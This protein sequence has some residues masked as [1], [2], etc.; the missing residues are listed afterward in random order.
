MLRELLILARAEVRALLRM[1]YT[2][3]VIGLAWGMMLM[4]LSLSGHR[5]DSGSAGGEWTPWM[6]WVNPFDLSLPAN[7]LVW[8]AISGLGV[9]GGAVRIAAM[10]RDGRWH[11]LSGL[12]TGTTRT[13]LGIALGR[14]IVLALALAV[15][16]VPVGLSCCATPIGEPLWRTLTMLGVAWLV[17]AHFLTGT[18]ALACWLPRAWMAGAGATV[19]T[20]GWAVIST[21]YP[22]TVWPEI[23]RLFAGVGTTASP[24]WLLRSTSVGV[25][26]V[27]LVVVE[28]LTLALHIVLARVGFSVTRFMPRE[29]KS[30]WQFDRRNALIRGSIAIAGLAG[31]SLAAM[32]WPTDI[33]LTRARMTEPGAPLLQ[34]VNERDVA[35]ELRIPLDRGDSAIW[36]AYA[37]RLQ[38][39]TD[40]RIVWSG[41]HRVDDWHGVIARA[42]DHGDPLLVELGDWPAAYSRIRYHDVDAMLRGAADRDIISAANS[43]VD[44]DTFEAWLET[45]HVSLSVAPANAIAHLEA[46]AQSHLAHQAALN[47]R[48][49]RD[50]STAGADVQTRPRLRDLG[51]RQRIFLLGV[52]GARERD[53]WRRLLY[54]EGFDVDALQFALP[55]DGG[56]APA[57]DLF[58]LA[59]SRAL[60]ISTTDVRKVVDATALG[61]SAV[62]VLP[63]PAAIEPQLWREG[64]GFPAPLS[65]LLQHY[66]LNVQRATISPTTARA[67]RRDHWNRREVQAVAF[68]FNARALANSTELLWLHPRSYSL[69]IALAHLAP[70][71]PI[72]Q[73]SR[74]R[75]AVGLPQA[76]T[77]LPRPLGTPDAAPLIVWRPLESKSGYDPGMLAVLS[78]EAFDIASN[79]PIGENERNLLANILARAAGRDS[80]TQ[81]STV[82][83]GTGISD[84]MAPPL[85]SLI[86]RKPLQPRSPPPI[87][88]RSA[89]AST[90]TLLALQLRD[91]PTV[92]AEEPA[93]TDSAYD[94]GPFVY[95]LD[96]AYL[97]AYIVPGLLLALS[98]WRVIGRRRRRR[99]IT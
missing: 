88:Q 16:I 70:A 28:L 6:V 62:I 29:A 92:G 82:L 72:A 44:P 4:A 23:D 90:S 27:T 37:R 24:F 19:F 69:D 3:A 34:V 31:L 59:P 99:A 30:R 43:V 12:P 50:A 38:A 15:V 73:D 64:G 87:G 54:S 8:I 65:S 26:P 25:L 40:G 7:A 32:L 91:D 61:C 63:D 17:L 42:C 46:V 14:F 60:S 84:S 21:W 83:N 51:P 95:V 41:S 67:E 66:G 11:S 97:A 53:A 58:I 18:I 80:W 96:G 10:R 86:A 56:I 93:A 49:L 45:A 33:D 81:V 78:I 36:L 94:L 1:R 57:R 89:G 68:D 22:L 2:I 47:Q 13:L 55:R 39:R 79:E 5:L 20:A 74:W 48:V 75:V 85:Q 35:G 76:I 71:G 77:V 98:L 52:D 9:Y